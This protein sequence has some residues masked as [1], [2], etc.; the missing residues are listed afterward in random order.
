VTRIIVKN[1]DGKAFLDIPVTAG[2]VGV[3]IAPL[4]AAVGVIAA[5]ATHCT[6]VVERKNNPVQETVVRA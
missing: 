4:L 1:E 5:L 3:L 2:V 6:L